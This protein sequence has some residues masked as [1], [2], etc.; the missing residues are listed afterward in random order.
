MAHATILVVDDEELV[1]WSLRARFVADG[2]TVVEAGTAA[3]ALADT[4]GK[5]IV[6]EFARL[7]LDHIDTDCARTRGIGLSADDQPA[8]RVVSGNA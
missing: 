8:T 2:H 4:Y 3:E 6:S 5:A 1:R 7:L